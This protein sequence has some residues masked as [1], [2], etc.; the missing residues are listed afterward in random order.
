MPRIIEQ[1][2]HVLDSSREIKLLN[3]DSYKAKIEETLFGQEEAAQRLAA[4]AVRLRSGIGA[5][6]HKPRGCFVEIG[7]SGSGKT[8]AVP[9]LIRALSQEYSNLSSDEL[10]KRF[11]IKINCAD[12]QDDSS[13]QHNIAR[14]CC[15]EV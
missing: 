14:S 8:E 12:F 2:Q 4:I 5:E 3:T 15:S 7:P 1:S 6:T 13:Q 10:L 11:C 9:A